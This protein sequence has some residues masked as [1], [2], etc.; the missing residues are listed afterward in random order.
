MLLLQ[1]HHSGYNQDDSVII[2]KSAVERGLFNSCYFK[3]YDTKEV[4]DTRGELK[5]YFYNPNDDEDELNEKIIKNKSYN[6]SH[7]DNTG[8]AKEGSYVFDND[9][10]ISKYVSRL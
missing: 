6:Y 3:T 7:A 2:N 10:L 4:I 9:V 5:E 8:F 1:L